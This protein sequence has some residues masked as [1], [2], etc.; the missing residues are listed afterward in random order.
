MDRAEDAAEGPHV[1]VFQIGAVGPAVDDRGHDVAPSA[2]HL[3]QVELRGQER[4]LRVSDELVVHEQRH[5]RLDALEHHRRAAVLPGHR[6]REGPGVDTDLVGVRIDVGDPGRALADRRRVR[7]GQ[8]VGDAVPLQLPHSGDGDPVAARRAGGAE[9]HG[10][11]PGNTA[12]PVEQPFAGQI[13]A[14]VVV[15]R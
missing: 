15:R 7:V 5:P 9:I 6:H 2:H 11:Q 4:P 13:E 10:V 8:V 12:V 1:L 14:E 3:G